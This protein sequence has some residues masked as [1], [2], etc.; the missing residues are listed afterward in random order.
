MRIFT[1]SILL[2]LSSLCSAAV[3]YDLK[4]SHDIVH[5]GSWS[6]SYKS[7][8]LLASAIENKDTHATR[9]NIL[10]GIISRYAFMQEL[11]RENIKPEV[12]EKKFQQQY[13][14]LLVQF[15]TLDKQEKENIHDILE[16]KL[17]QH[18]YTRDIGLINEIHTAEVSLNKVAE[19]VSQKEIKVYYDA[20]KED[21][22]NVDTIEAQHIKLDSQKK[23]D[24]GYA[25]LQK[26]LDCNT[27]VIKYSMDKDKDSQPFAGDLGSIKNGSIKTNLVEKIALLEPVNKVSSPYR[28]PNGWHIYFVRSQTKKR[29]ALDE[30]ISLLV[31]IRLSF[32]QG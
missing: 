1:A 11:E 27:A 4:D 9:K 2:T 6:L 29:L 19:K 28:T 10:A 23:A 20:N 3:N 13:E 7:F 32:L 5:V 22:I 31:L 18:Q 16:S 8:D 25:L 21:F 17:V 30:S 24:E 26:G 12:N 15:P 14:N